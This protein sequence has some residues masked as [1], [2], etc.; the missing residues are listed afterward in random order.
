MTSPDLFVI[1]L[2]HIGIFWFI[3]PFLSLQILGMVPDAIV[4]SMAG[5]REGHRD[6][7]FERGPDGRWRLKSRDNEAQR[8]APSTNPLASLRG[9]F[10]DRNLAPEDSPPANY[11]MFVDLIYRML[12]YNSD[13]RITPELALE[14]PFIVAGE[15]DVAA[16]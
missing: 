13:E 5:D 14:H 7:F 8:I 16:A 4:D 2:S 12:L 11:D 9:I 6:Q 15:R 3:S 10:N 1:L